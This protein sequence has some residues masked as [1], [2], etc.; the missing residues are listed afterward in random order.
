MGKMGPLS[1]PLEMGNGTVRKDGHLQ[2]Y[3]VVSRRERRI[4][5]GELE[6][7]PFSESS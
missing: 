5:G 6:R 3:T 4:M 7:R 1:F 2:G